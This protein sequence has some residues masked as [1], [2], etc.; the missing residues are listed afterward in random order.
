MEYKDL[1]KEARENGAWDE[2]TMWRAVE[3]ISEMLEDLK[4]SNPKAFWAFMREQ[5]GIMYGRH[6][7][8]K[9]AMHDVA[10]M[11]WKDKEGKTRSG[12]YWTLERVRDEIKGKTLPKGANIYDAFVAYNATATDLCTIL[13]EKELGEVAFATWFD[14]VDWSETGSATKIWD[15]MCCKFGE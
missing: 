2:K 13:S 7:N 10:K 6:Y 4:E 1:V 15:Y 14:D 11:L 5:H 9:F 8:E 12:A 3:S